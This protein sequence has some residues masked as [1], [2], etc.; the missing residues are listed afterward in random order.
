MSARALLRL[1]DMREEPQVEVLG[2]GPAPGVVIRHLAWLLMYRFGAAVVS[3]VTGATRLVDSFFSVSSDPTCLPKGS[4]T[5]GPAFRRVVAIVST[6]RSPLHWSIEDRRFHEGG[7]GYAPT[8]VPRKVGT[9][10]DVAK[11]S[12]HGDRI[13][14]IVPWPGSWFSE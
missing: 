8:C 1:R 4:S 13:W 11:G 3:T 9:I 12:A 10:F 14:G 7:R 6:A 5:L 2:D